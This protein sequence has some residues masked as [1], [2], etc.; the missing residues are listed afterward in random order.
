[1]QTSLHKPV[2]DNAH[3]QPDLVLLANAAGEGNSTGL[4]TGVG[5]QTLKVD[6]LGPVL[7]AFDSAALKLQIRQALIRREM[8][9]ERPDIAS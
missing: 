5:V 9:Y 7:I 2:G 1:M 4:Q 6:I 8:D 3:R